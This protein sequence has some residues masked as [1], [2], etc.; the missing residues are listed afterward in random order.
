M[1]LGGGSAA[2]VYVDVEGDLSKFRKDVG[3]AGDIASKEL[4]GKSSKFGTASKLV[5]GAIVGGVVAGAV[6]GISEAIEREQVDLN[7]AGSLGLEID[8]AEMVALT[9]GTRNLYSNAWGE[10]YEEVAAAQRDTF[11][12][13][14]FGEPQQ[15]E[16][17]TEKALAISQAFGL[18]VE[19]VLGTASTAFYSG[20][21]KDDP[22]EI[23][24][25]IAASAGQVPQAL[26]GEILAAGSEYSQFFNDLGFGSQEAFG[27]LVA[28]AGDGAYGID[29]A[30]DAIK[31]FTIRAT[32]GSTATIDAF[33]AIGVEGDE[34]AN[35]FLAG[36]ET[37][38]AAFDE[39][40]AGLLAIEDPAARAE[41]AIALFGTPLEDLGVNDIP[42]FLSGLQDGTSA[43]AD[44]EGAAGELA[45]T[46]GDSTQAKLESFKRRGLDVLA[47]VATEV[48]IPALDAIIPPLE[49]ML[50]FV[51]AMPAPVQA[52]AGGAAL[53]G[54]SL[55]FLAGPI[56]NA[57]KLVG[58]FFK[59]LSAN[60]Y[61]LI[62]AA[63]IAI[64]Y[65]I[66]TNWDSIV[67]ALSAAWEW[68]Q[69]TASTVWNAIRG[70]FEEWWRV[71]LVVF[72]GG[73]GAIAL[74]IFDNWDRIWGK[75]VEI[76]NGISG[77]LEGVLSGIAG[78]FQD[79]ILGP[80]GAIF[81]FFEDLP[82]IARSAWDGVSGAISSAKDGILGAL[83]EI[84]S[85]A[86]RALG[87]LDEIAGFV[88]GGVGGLL[89]FDNGG[90]VPGPKGAPRLVLAHG[91][92]T[93][94]PTHKRGNDGLGGGGGGD[95]YNVTVSGSMRNEADAVRL[96]R[97]LADETRRVKRAK[98]A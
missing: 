11:A 54:G 16:Q 95:V 69:E 33:T 71:I 87:P 84:G 90:V 23:F 42:Q 70:F 81:G 72:T 63:T 64:A 67:A 17:W 30:G 41:A 25:A 28:N 83:G 56:A 80:V 62:I 5:G 49:A 76:W 35:R 60:P 43:M 57:T 39:T 22:M 7:V 15:I 96:G 89:G 88:I 8:S 68:I 37:A 73:L 32:D 31:E 94:I 27:I 66:I 93:F 19:E 77:F 59:L 14:D 47:R 79:Y 40:V 44:M 13:F 53:L 92:E 61:V 85:A 6:A 46:I 51:E 12:A 2:S 91:G 97:I 86:D 74:W 26:Q 58:G 18:S 34:M 1:A 52:F 55:I 45:D 36:G 4:G 82:G 3:E 65:L 48:L 10:T 75:T 21:T 38:K 50:S 29:K 24:D 78:F 20:L 98:G 9:E